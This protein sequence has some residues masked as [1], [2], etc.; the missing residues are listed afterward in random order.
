MIT[1]SD[2]IPGSSA[3]SSSQAA[4]YTRPS[5]MV[6][7]RNTGVSA[8][9]H[10]PAARKPVH[11]PAPLRTAAQAGPMTAPGDVGSLA[12]VEGMPV[13]WHPDCLAHEPDGEVWLGVWEAGTEVP[14]RASVLLDA[15]S[16]AGA[17]VTPAT[18]HDDAVILAVH[19]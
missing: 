17:A 7:V 18:L 19:D 9:P 10:S 12:I 3:I 4:S 13:V 1:S 8:N 6:E 2:P 11:S 5:C 15:L 16:S 14:E